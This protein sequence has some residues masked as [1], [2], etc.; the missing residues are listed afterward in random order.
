ML[1]DESPSGDFS[2]W[3]RSLSDDEQCTV[4]EILRKEAASLGV[5]VTNGGVALRQK[6]LTTHNF[7]E[8]GTGILAKLSFN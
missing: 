5:I 1:F 6:P 4:L 3:F 7:F 2:E 8:R